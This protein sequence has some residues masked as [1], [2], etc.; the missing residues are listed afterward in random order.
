MKYSAC[1]FHILVIAAV[2]SA[3]EKIQLTIPHSEELGTLCPP[4]FV[5]SNSTNQCECYTNPSLNGVVKCTDEAALLRLGYCTTYQKGAGLSVGSCNYLRPSLYEVT[6]DNYIRLPD[7]TSE[8]NDY[9]CG[10][11][12]RKGELCSE[13]MDGFGPSIF[14]V[15]PICSNCTNAWYGVP[16]YLFLEFVPITIFYF[17]ILFF[18][19][20]V[21][22]APMVAFVFFS[23]IG[24]STLIVITNRYISDTSI[25]FH[26]LSVLTTFYG[27][28]NLDFFRH[29][30]PPFCVSP[31]IKAIH[32]TFLYCVSAFYPL[33]LIALTALCIK[34]HSN[35]NVA[36]VWLWKKLNRWSC[37]RRLT[38][39]QDVKKT[40]VDVF[41]TFI[42]LSY[43]KLLFTCVRTLTL[44]RRYTLSNSLLMTSFQV[45]S[46]PSIGFFSVEHLPFAL[47]SI[48]ILLFVIAPL[49]LL[50]T[51]YPLGSFRV[52]LF[53][54]IKSHTAAL[55]LFVEKFYSCYRDSLD[56]GR[57]MRSFVSVYF[58]LRLIHFLFSQFA[59]FAV[60]ISL[61][62]IS[63]ILIA[64]AQPYKKSYMNIIDT[65]ILLDIAM[66]ALVT[67]KIIEQQQL[68][69]FTTLYFIAA[70]LLSSIPLLGLSGYLI[71]KI[72]QKLIMRATKKSQT[73]SITESRDTEA[74]EQHNV[75]SGDY[76]LPDRVLHPEEY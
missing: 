6:E 25:A 1:I 48:V 64:L 61:F 73:G 59:F 62:M 12:N 57:D 54:C 4:W 24:V 28:W 52:V 15:T 63:S 20:S 51:L 22:S 8:L 43:A 45:R 33:C 72:F 46:D 35:H 14:T 40:I 41:A 53:A 30:L 42:L 7:N 29:V 55:N 50:L 68:E 19:I 11:V 18:R 16:L 27:V 2:T 10:P 23:Q 17:I 32:I 34:L 39:N 67:D 9:L 76:E 13:C 21:T 49:T 75:R 5:Y 31:S 56:G 70:S 60:N 69:I 36:I 66:I 74:G 26:F 47:A 71:Y 3:D 58:L 65:L 37:L 44:D 38:S